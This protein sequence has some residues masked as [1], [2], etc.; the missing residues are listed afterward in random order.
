MTVGF[1]GGKPR[2]IPTK[3][4]IRTRTVIGGKMAKATQT[5]GGHSSR[6]SNTTRPKALDFWA[7]SR[8]S[9]SR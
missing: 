4:S 6:S 2:L 1:P 9:R 7:Q 3:S 8:S 5:Q